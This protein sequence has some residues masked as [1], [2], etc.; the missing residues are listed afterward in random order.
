VVVADAP[1]L[2]EERLSERHLHELFQSPDQPRDTD[3]V[4]A[5]ER[6]A[7]AFI[8]ARGD[9]LRA[10]LDEGSSARAPACS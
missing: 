6:F 1:V 10:A 3:R 5:L 9:A 7:Y 2:K 4:L 8:G